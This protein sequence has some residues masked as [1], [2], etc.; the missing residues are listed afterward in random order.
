MQFEA[1][2]NLVAADL[3]ATESLIN[4][5]FLADIPLINQLSQHIISS[6]GKR[7]RP[8]VV[9]LAAKAFGYEGTAHHTLAAIIELIHTATLLHDDVIDASSL[10]RG[11][12]TANAVW[13]NQASVLVGDYLYSRA[14]QMMVEV[15]QIDIIAILAKA[16]NT[17]VEGEILQLVNM[18]DPDT[19]EAC[20]REVIARKTGALFGVAAE[21]G[22][23]LTHRNHQE[24]IAMTNYGKH[25]GI[26]FQLID[27]ALD[28][29]SD[30]ATIG[31]NCGD[32][33]AEGKPTLPVIYALQKAD[34]KTQKII[35]EIIKNK[36]Q[37]AFEI[38]LQA[39]ESTNA[40]SYTYDAA[41][42]EANK[43]IAELAI[44]PDSPYRNALIALAEFAV[45]RHH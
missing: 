19:T 15:K 16:T 37:D 42:T 38:I 31:K 11:R 40:L 6:G 22:A 23:A 20:Y 30:A 21:L 18:G 9:L 29:M 7:M 17:I 44:I 45:S 33:L 32:D 24:T 34:E 8:L 12:H 26:A 1:I 35:R 13:G 36:Q 25:L 41:K 28:Y 14:F 27:D 10:R 5:C 2:R 4:R 43:A 39:I 3:A